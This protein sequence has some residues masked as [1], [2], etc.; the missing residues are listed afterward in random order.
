MDR[1]AHCTYGAVRYCSYNVVKMCTRY[2]STNPDDSV[3]YS[4]KVSNYFMWNMSL[5]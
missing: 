2:A 5:K 4:Y 3:Y 1:T